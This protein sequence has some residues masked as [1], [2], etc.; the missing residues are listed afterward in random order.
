MKSAVV[1]SR[2]LNIWYELYLVFCWFPFLAKV[3]LCMSEPELW[4][5]K[6]WTKEFSG[7]GSYKE[8]E[9]CTAKSRCRCC[10]VNKKHLT[11]NVVL[12]EAMNFCLSEDFIFKL[13]TL[14]TISVNT[15][16]GRCVEVLYCCIIL[17]FTAGRPTGSVWRGGGRMRL[18]LTLILT[19]YSLLVV[20][21]PV[22]ETHQVEVTIKVLDIKGISVLWLLGRMESL[23][24]EDHCRDARD[25]GWVVNDG[26]PS[27]DPG[28]RDSVPLNKGR[29][30]HLHVPEENENSVLGPSDA[31]VLFQLPCW[32]P[33]RGV[34]EAEDVD[35]THQ[36]GVA[37]VKANLPW[38]VVLTRAFVSFLEQA[39]RFY[40]S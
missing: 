11:T 37:P 16:I 35:G 33:G 18:S 9:S 34:E 7:I 15:G 22:L 31:V 36:A 3:R 29:S 1:I 17:S 10:I 5:T 21:R 38:T 13:F 14:T 20:T 30:I 28:M 4:S 26:N 25:E 27:E 32:P 24:V 2:D 19:L 12:K 40:C 8:L 23:I 39:S 6:T